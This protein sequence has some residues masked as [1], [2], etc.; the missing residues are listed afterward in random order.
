[1]IELSFVQLIFKKKYFEK[2]FIL[3]E[4]YNLPLF[5]H[6]RNASEDF[7][8]IISRNRDRFKDGVV[9]SFDGNENELN[10]LIDLNLYIGIN[11]C[12][13]KTQENLDVVKKIP[14]DRL[15]IET[16]APWCQ[17]RSTHAGYQHIKTFFPE[18]QK[19]KWDSC[20]IKG[21]NEPTHLI[22]ILE[23]ISSIR[24]ES[25]SS[26]SETIYNNTVKVFDKVK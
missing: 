23:V 3:A 6:L 2:Q 12:S 24:E 10:R 19:N 14:I 7:L 5:L 16:D 13:L 25:I 4:K 15:M 21:R 9:H 11:G 20:I 22:Q 17:I 1:M 18:K 8:D 26:I